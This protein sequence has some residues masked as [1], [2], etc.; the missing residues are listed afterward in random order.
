MAI[1]QGRDGRIKVSTDQGKSWAELKRLMGFDPK[2]ERPAAGAAGTLTRAA[3][4][5]LPTQ[6]E[7]RIARD[8]QLYA[9]I[10][11][12]MPL[13]MRPGRRAA[14]QRYI[15]TAIAHLGRRQLELV[16]WPWEPKPTRQR[17]PR[18]RPGRPGDRGA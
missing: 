17:V 10:A 7:R 5:A 13:F 8:K 11:K 12:G 2:A 9:T 16:V 1:I 18:G 3:L 14:A 15:N 6:L 4:K